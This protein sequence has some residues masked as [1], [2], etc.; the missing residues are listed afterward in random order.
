[1]TR[2]DIVTA[3]RGWRGIPFVHQGRTRAGVDCI[4]LVLNV[5]WELGAVPRTYDITGYSRMPDGSLFSECDR[6]LTR[7]SKP[8]IGSILV[9]RFDEE[10]QHI[11]FFAQYNGHPSVIHALAERP[12][13]GKVVEHR[14]TADWPSKVVGCFDFPGVV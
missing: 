1:M 13:G 2:D 7:I 12:R 9:M 14:L 8:Q 4:G 5:A 3:A 11:G 10:P 6:L